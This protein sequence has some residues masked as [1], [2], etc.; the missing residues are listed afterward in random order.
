[1]TATACIESNVF[2]PARIFGATVH[3]SLTQNML[4]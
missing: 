4:F 1:M 2:E 3:C